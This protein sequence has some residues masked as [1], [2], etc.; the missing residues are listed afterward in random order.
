MQML[1]PFVTICG[2]LILVAPAAADWPVFRGDTAQTGVVAEPLPDKLAVRWQ[3][4]TGSDANTAVI[5]GTAAIAGGVAFVGAF[6]DHLH[7]YDIRTGLEK[8]KLKTGTIKSPVGVRAGSVYAGT[9]DGVLYCV[10]AAGKE[11]WKYNV[12]SE[13]SSGVNFTDDLVLFGTTDETLHAVALA[14]GK[15]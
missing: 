5:E 4:K 6:D 3:A 13:V 12:E 9:V 2:C 1:K 11:K 10:D 14:D 7:A 15:P 8:W